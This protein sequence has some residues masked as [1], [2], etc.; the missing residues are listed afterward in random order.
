M[1]CK[2]FILFCARM[3]PMGV[4]AGM[5]KIVLAVQVCCA[6]DYMLA[7]RL[8]P[9]YLAAIHCSYCKLQVLVLMNGVT[10]ISANT[11]TSI[12]QLY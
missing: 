3:D 6:Q 12:A 4:P 8:D 7:V 9:I 5:P 1:L 11:S 10:L 2:I